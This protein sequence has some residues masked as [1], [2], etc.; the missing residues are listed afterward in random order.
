MA[1]YN[2]EISTIFKSLHSSN[3]GIKETSISARKSQFGTNVLDK[4]KPLSF[5]K[6]L[7]LQF[8]NIMIIILLISAIISSVLAITENDFENLFEGL[9]I[10]LIVFVNAIIGVVQEQKAEDALTALA[11]STEPFA[12]V[13]RDGKT[14]KVKVHELVVG[15]IILLKAGNQVP[16]DIRIFESQNLKCNESSLTGESHSVSKKSTTLLKKNI[17]LSDQENICF[18]G[19]SVTSGSGK[20]IVVAVGKDTELGKIA[21]ILGTQIKEKTPLEKNIDKIGKVLTIGILFIV[22]IVFLIQVLF[23]KNI[24]AMQ[25]LLTAVALAV[26]AIPESLPAVITIIMALGV[27]RLARKNAIIKKL[28]A[29]ETLGCCN[30][31]CSDKTGT[32][33]KNEMNVRHIYFSQGLFDENSKEFLNNEIFVKTCSLCN[34]IIFDKENTISADAT[35]TAIG[36]FLLKNNIDITKTKNENRKIYE[37]EFSSSKKFMSVVCEKGLDKSLYTKGALDYVLP[38]CTKILI[39]GEERPLTENIKKRILMA[40]DSVCYNG[41]RVIS[42]AFKQNAED[43][44]EK[45]LTFIGFFGIIDPPRDEVFDSI[46]LCKKA[47]LTTIM[48]TGD[49]PATALSIAKSLGLAKS[50]K[51]VLTGYELSQI[52][53]N[54]LKK[55][56][57]NYRVFARVTPE[58]KLRLVKALKANNKIVAMTGDGVN[59]APSIKSANIGV[60]MGQTGT[61]V[62]KEVSDVIISDDNFATIVLAIKEGR[63]IYQN[64]TKTIIFLLSTNI[65]EVL[66]IFVTSLV[67]PNSI[68]LLPTQI[69]FVNL[70]TDSLPA[71]ALGIEPAEKDIM[72]IPPRDANK[73]LLSGK[74]GWT[75]IYQG[76]I[77]SLVVLVMFVFACNYFGN[78]I[79]STMSFLTICLMQIIHAINCKSEHS[80]FKTNIFKNHF[81]N[82]SFLTLL[83]LIL[84]VYFVPFL[85]GLFGLVSIS[86]TEWLIVIITS[87]AIIPT[88]EIGKLIIN[89]KRWKTS[90]FIIIFYLFLVWISNN[91]ISIIIHS[92]VVCKL[93]FSKS[94]NTL[95]NNIT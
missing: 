20:G 35:E 13:V 75:I 5:F 19:T 71:F 62:S 77:Q 57:L 92:K 64:I 63:A 27:Q 60:C 24:S 51:E 66:G 88:V 42:F 33:T 55:I 15:D 93:E 82:F 74:T 69:L 43:F 90:L 12:T 85:S 17:P 6:K 8:K 84:I 37:N 28:S 44:K 14:Q 29:V 36:K 48:I 86:L 65:V 87:L 49:H 79:A 45:E 30:V 91:S 53:D 1:Y 89:K 9:L 7:L 32:L 72:N 54:D 11:K 3:N 38:L 16:A 58:H 68:F 31:I 39:N 41:E 40:N 46:R 10:F 81:F 83:G 47:G 18:S 73:S 76:F 80:I 21:K 95:Q 22:S 34:N 4:Q 56:V 70:V 50:K 67:M 59:D 52:S 23:N 25:A 78:E 94:V 26:A 61:D 2:D